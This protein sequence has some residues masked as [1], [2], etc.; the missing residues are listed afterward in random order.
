MA[1]SYEWI[2]AWTQS[3]LN[4]GEWVWHKKWVMERQS[5]GWS[6]RQSTVPGAPHSLQPEDGIGGGRWEQ[7]RAGSSLPGFLWMGGSGAFISCTFQRSKE[8]SPLLRAEKCCR[9]WSLGTR[10]ISER[11]FNELLLCVSNPRGVLFSFCLL[12]LKIS[13]LA[14]SA[15]NSETFFLH[16]TH[17]YTSDEKWSMIRLLF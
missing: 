15:L 2:W 7:G 17:T 9:H 6:S 12:F 14:Y 5:E 11:L 16:H 3:V 1:P 8:L 10:G 4:S 13:N